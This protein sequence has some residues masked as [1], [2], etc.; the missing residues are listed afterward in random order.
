MRPSSFVVVGAVAGLVLPACGKK[1]DKKVEVKAE[2]TV[3]VVPKKEVPT[4]QLPPL[5]ADP[6]GATGKPVWQAG[7]G[8]L[9]IDSPR[10]IAVGAAGEVYICG[11]IEGEADFGG[12]VGKKKSAGKS[13]AFLAKL[14]ATGKLAWAHTW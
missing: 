2:T 10:A 14:D 4:K 12:S 6:G 11:Y 13:D 5:A 9:G 3:A 1:E 7:F 8:G